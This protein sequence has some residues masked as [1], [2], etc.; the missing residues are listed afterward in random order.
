MRKHIS[1]SFYVQILDKF[2]ESKLVFNFLRFYFD[3][4]IFIINVNVA[5]HLY[6]LAKHL[7]SLLMLPV[8]I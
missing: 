5:K 7:Y 4:F 6:S 2:H 3:E 8:N 1:I